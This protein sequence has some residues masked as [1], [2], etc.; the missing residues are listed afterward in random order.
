VWLAAIS[1]ACAS[2]PS[3]SIAPLSPGSVP[4]GRVVTAFDA[5]AELARG[6][7]LE[8]DRYV[9]GLPAAE[10]E[11]SAELLFLAG[12]ARLARGDA[13]GARRALERALSLSLSGPKRADALWSLAQAEILTDD[14]AAAA[15]D[16]AAANREGLSLSIGFVHF[17]EN[18]AGVPLYAGMAPG[19]RIDTDF[20][21]G[22]YDLVRVGMAVNGHPVSA[23]LDT[24]ASYCIL[25]RSFATRVGL[26][27]IP[28][29]DAY[30]LGLHQKPIPLTFG[31]VDELRIAGRTLTAIPVMVMPD[32]AL[33]FETARGSLPI[34][35]V[36]GL[37]MLKNF[38]L[39][40]DYG[41][42][43]LG[44]EA[45]AREFDRPEP[46]QNLFFARAK[47]FARVSVDGSPWTLFLLDTGSELTMLT[48]GGVQRLG[49]RTASG[50]FP[51]RV[52]G[53]GK[54]R[55]SWGKVDRA[56]LGVGAFRLDFRD[57]VVAETVDT[58]E[59]GVLG[60]TVLAHFAVRID[61]Q[62]MR[63]ELTTRS[64]AS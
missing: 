34:S 12:R 15:R 9:D 1:V 32:E 62:K 59:D 11:G 33:T 16:T 48:A 25:T 24:G 53:I 28:D 58:L 20:E 40:I 36:L 56:A 7:F 41:S 57:M 2:N 19:E 38:R 60:A 22:L 23:V 64:G 49:L 6:R 54:T 21:M 30:G 46:D 35:A 37:H 10:R 5:E 61:F 43:R 14:F 51:K 29:S 17:L 26:R 27:E 39:E 8:V 31:V 3:V 18:L 52:E 42:R 4:A 55:V 45:A 47:V 44:M 13:A 50:V 63:L